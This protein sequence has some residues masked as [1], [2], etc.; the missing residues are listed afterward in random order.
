MS[1]PPASR[2]D[3]SWPHSSLIV[4]TPSDPPRLAS[5]LT[6]RLED[7]EHLVTRHALDLGN[8]VRVTEDDADLGR[9][10]TAT[11]ELEDL[12]ADLL[13]GGLG[14][15]GLGTAV[16][17]GRGGHALAFGVHATGCVSGAQRDGNRDVG[18]VR[19]DPSWR[20]FYWC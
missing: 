9:G 16:R 18:G 13:G 1:A 7:T 14:P 3:S 12:V 6:V 19:T 11:G 8:A 15:R 2:P 5:Q 4:G 20:D 10:E 17:E